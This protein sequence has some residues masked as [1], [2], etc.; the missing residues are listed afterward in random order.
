MELDA[1]IFKATVLQSTELVAPRT[2]VLCS[3]LREDGA[4][5][6]E[7][8]SAWTSE[9]KNPEL[10]PPELCLPE[11]GN[12]ERL[13]RL[14]SEQQQSAG[15]GEH[16]QESEARPPGQASASLRI[17]G[18]VRSLLHCRASTSVDRGGYGHLL[19]ECLWG[20]DELSE[21]SFGRLMFSAQLW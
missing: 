21:A 19:H 17:P 14:A 16:A 3:V 8:H 1:H 20:S 9:S 4:Y 10:N 15:Q 18:L 5:S 6:L 12:V 11:A 2:D 7:K 13:Q